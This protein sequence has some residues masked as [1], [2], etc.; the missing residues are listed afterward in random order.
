MR[1]ESQTH[2]APVVGPR[3]PQAPSYAP[4]PR[5]FTQGCRVKQ[6]KCTLSPNGHVTHNV[7]R[8]PSP[9][10]APLFR[11]A[12]NGPRK[13]GFSD[14]DQV[15]VRVHLRA[16]VSI[17]SAHSVAADGVPGHGTGSPNAPVHFAHGVQV[18]AHLAFWARARSSRPKHCNQ[19]L[20]RSSTVLTAPFVDSTGR[21]EQPFPRRR[22]ARRSA[23]CLAEGHT[24]GFSPLRRA[25]SRCGRP[26]RLDPDLGKNSRG[27]HAVLGD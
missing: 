3:A 1:N 5:V 23:A 6:R 26:G 11:G 19:S 14:V 18:C 22:A 12:K 2:P 16:P 9:R 4:G 15:A 24:S 8:R 21:V 10:L 13:R 17:S 20:I 25:A 7:A 27:L